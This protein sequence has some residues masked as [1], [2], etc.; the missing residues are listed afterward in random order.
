[1]SRILGYKLSAL[2][3]K[4]VR[5]AAGSGLASLVG[6]GVLLLAAGMFLDFFFELPRWLRA[7]FLAVDLSAL[8]YILFVEVLA[9]IVF[10]PDDEDVALM[11]EHAIPGFRTRLIASVQL[12]EAGAIPAGG[13]K[14]LVREMIRQT[15][16]FAAPLDFSAIVNT[17]PFVRSLVLGLFLSTLGLSAFVYTREVSG[18]LLKRAFLADVPVPRK[19]RVTCLT[20]NRTIAI[21]D[22][23]NLEAL[24]QGIIPSSGKVKI[25]YKSG[26]EQTFTIEPKPDNPRQ[27]VRRIENVQESFTYYIRLNDG[28]S[29]DY[30]IEAVA[31]PAVTSMELEQVYPK[32]TRRAPERRSPGDLLL[33][34]GSDLQ[35]KLKATKRVKQ[36][37]IHLVGL[38]R[39]I[40]MAVAGGAREQVAGTIEK[41][42]SRGLTGFSIRLTD[43]FGISS[44]SETV[45]PIDVLLDKDPT[46]RIVWPDRKEELVTQQAR[47]LVAFEATDDFGLA[48]VLL[49]Y[50][51]DKPVTAEVLAPGEEKFIELDLSKEKPDDLRHL[52]RRYEFDLSVL[53]PTPLEGSAIEYWLE[54][55]DGN[56]VTGPGKAFSD[57]FRAR[58]VSEIAKRADLMNRLNDQ[59]GT[60][61]SVT[62]DEEKL[63]QN[64]GALLFEKPQK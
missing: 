8:T 2:R 44:A 17:G 25:E 23:V 4:H 33:L 28:H 36:G 9:P 5:V 26:R 1:M 35:V 52:A 39:E 22:S 37:V 29:P 61:D 19:T 45:Y 34:A 40:A 49:H 27:F 24:A 10:G 63:N 7:A 20:Q 38:D 46:V 14:S 55:R 54:V 13:S 31:R 18:D 43:D 41:I 47:I 59:L 15:E 60:I 48:R 21:G 3:S 58:I 51:V 50:R 42:P 30:S 62:Q 16:E 12:S 53:K 11:V 57:R 64:L 6:L 56:D 32:Y